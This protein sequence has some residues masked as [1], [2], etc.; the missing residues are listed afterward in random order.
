M[1]I[2]VFGLGYVGAVSCGCLSALGHRVIGCDT[3]AAKVAL[4]RDGRPPIDEKGLADLLR[5]A[6]ADGRLSATVDAAEAIRAADAALI[7]VGT[8]SDRNG[9]VRTEFLEAVCSQIG[10][11]LREQG[12]KT[13]T[14][15]TRSTAL[16]AVHRRL[17]D[18]LCRESGLELGSELHY[19]CHPE[20]LREGNAVDDFYK[21]PKIVF[22]LSHPDCR[23]SCGDLYPGIPGEVFFTS[24]EE[25]AMVK[26]ADNC[27][28]AVKVTFANEIGG[29]C[30]EHG[31]DARRVMDIFCSDR[32]LNISERYLRPGAAFGG[33]CLPK[34][35]RAV[36]D[37]AR[38]T[39]LEL[40][41]LSGA[42]RSNDLQVRRLVERAM[43]RPQA[44]I[45]IVGLA[46]KEGTDDVRESPMVSVVE[47]LGGKG[48]PVRIYDGHL[49]VGRMI[50]ANLQFALASIPHLADALTDD[51][52][53]LV[54]GSEVLIVSHRLT[55]EAWSRVAWSGQLILDV[56]G[57]KQLESLPNYCGLYW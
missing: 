33:S 23:K 35:L 14:V 25:A 17:Q 53:G 11:A 5:Q 16:P 44:R 13:F 28:H 12:R 2:S 10:A 49:A 15:L 7:C 45:G 56:A 41:M 34:D 8:P 36:L 9:G 27:F 52:P 54:S 40:P 30:R 22:G 1:N 39:A 4:I 51:L 48:H 38:I 47:I 55:P 19:V 6:T 24:V 46:F 31:V 50:G 42:L 3:N 32:Q 37:N 21:P 26:Y 18:I 29:L 57:V 20:F 43:V